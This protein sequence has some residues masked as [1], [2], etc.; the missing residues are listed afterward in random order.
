M[1]LIGVPCWASFLGPTYR[2]LT[3][4][5]AWPLPLSLAGGIAQAQPQVRGL[6]RREIQ[7]IAGMLSLPGTH[8]RALGDQVLEVAGRSGTRSARD[9][10][11][12][13]GTQ[14]PDEALRS[15]PEEACE[16]L[17]LAL[18]QLTPRVTLTPRPRSSASDGPA[19]AP[20]VADNSHKG[21]VSISYTWVA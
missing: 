10:D 8:E 9:G 15:R 19:L 6:A 1:G 17:V 12:V 3:A 13:F 7:G 2:G 4:R 16:D 14:A 5:V 18:V 21:H 11:I 20:L